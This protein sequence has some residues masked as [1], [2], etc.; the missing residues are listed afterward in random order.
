MTRFIFPVITAAA[1]L[2]TPVLRAQDIDAEDVRLIKSKLETALEANDFLLK[3]VQS[4]EGQ[5][6]QLKADQARLKS[7]LGGVGKDNVSQEQLKKVVDQLK[8]V[9]KKREADNHLVLDKLE[10]LKKVVAAA[11]AAAAAPIPA[12]EGPKSGGHKP[13]IKTPPPKTPA[14]TTSTADPDNDKPSATVATPPK[15]VLPAEYDYFEHTVASGESI[16]G[17]I[18][19][20]NKE[21]GLKIK[22][23]HVLEANPKLKPERLKAGQKVKIPVIK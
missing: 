18:A 16:G 10:D 8:E 23:A 13:T 22:L 2:A 7:D 1:L 20:Y 6:S 9:D 21:K 4:L 14:S 11:A 15:S 17:I 12:P 19:A 3:R 5:I